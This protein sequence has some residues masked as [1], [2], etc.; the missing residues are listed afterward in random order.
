MAHHSFVQFPGEVKPVETLDSRDSRFAA[1]EADLGYSFAG[2]IRI[3]GK[4]VSVVRHGDQAFVSG[5][6]PRV[7]DEVVVTGSVGK[8][9]S[10]AQ[11][12]RAA[13][14]CA[15]RAL[16]LLRQ[17]LG[18]LDRI[19]RVLRVTVYVKSAQGF[20]QHSTIGRGIRI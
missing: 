6:V 19:A 1:V 7:G 9:V 16:A 3:G 14:V 4:Y 11:G 2:Q 17:S 10:L 8:D 18:S 12:Q 15:M 5:Q 13:K 20:T